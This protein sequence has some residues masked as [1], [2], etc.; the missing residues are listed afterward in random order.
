MNAAAFPNTTPAHVVMGNPA[1]ITT[2][3]RGTAYA[4]FETIAFNFNVKIYV[5]SFVDQPVMRLELDK[6]IWV[7][8]NSVDSKSF[9]CN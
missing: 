3:A 2:W 5:R 7:C 9:A 6:D 4:V 1:P 8:Y